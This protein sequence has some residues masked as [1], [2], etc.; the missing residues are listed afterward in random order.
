MASARRI[1]AHGYSVY[2]HDK[3]CPREVERGGQRGKGASNIAD[4]KRVSAGDASPS[5][6]IGPPPPPPLNR[7]AFGFL[8]SFSA[9]GG[10]GGGLALCLWAPLDPL[11]VCSG[12]TKSSLT[13]PGAVAGGV[14][15]RWGGQ[16]GCYTPAVKSKEQVTQH[17]WLSKEDSFIY[18]PAG[19]HGCSTGRSGRQED[20]SRGFVKR[21]R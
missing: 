8:A 20:S 10:G 18:G 14:D 19:S 2:G 13:S 3:C 6:A 9:P 5:L 11:D 17:T 7:R 16:E 21:I 12:R 15:V 1:S 4:S